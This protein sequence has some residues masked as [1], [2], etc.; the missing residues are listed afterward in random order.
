VASGSIQ[1]DLDLTGY[2]SIP[3]IGW[4]FLLQVISAFGLAVA[5]PVLRHPLADPTGAAYCPPVA[6]NSSPGPGV[7]GRIG[8][9]T[10]TD[11]STQATRDGR[12]LYTYIGDSNPGQANGNNVNLNGGLW[13]DVPVAG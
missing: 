6:G 8:T 11:G 10:R 12:P 3:V 9:M 13:H 7:T 1:L 4:L 2:K 5:I